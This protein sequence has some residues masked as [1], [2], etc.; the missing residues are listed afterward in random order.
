MLKLLNITLCCN[1]TFLLMVQL[2]L[3][4]KNTWLALT[5]NYVLAYLVLVPETQ[6]V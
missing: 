6:L 2:G 3:G 5:R 4:T 1:F